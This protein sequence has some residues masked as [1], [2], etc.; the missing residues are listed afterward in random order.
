M[1]SYCNILEQNIIKNLTQEFYTQALHQC[2]ILITLEA[3]ILESEFFN[4][5]K[6]PVK[7]DKN[8]SKSQNIKNKFE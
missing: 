6:D 8:R 2:D 5:F 7:R 1:L 3:W 4:T